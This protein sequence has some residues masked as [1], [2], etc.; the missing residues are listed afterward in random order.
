MTKFRKVN[1]NICP[2][3]NLKNIKKW[4]SDFFQFF[5]GL[6]FFTNI[7]EQKMNA[8]VV[9]DTHYFMDIVSDNDGEHY[10]KDNINAVIDPERPL[11]IQWNGTT[12]CV[13]KDFLRRV[14]KDSSNFDS[15]PIPL[16]EKVMLF[17][18][19]VYYI[20][21]AFIKEL[22]ETNLYDLVKG[23]EGCFAVS[24]FEIVY[25]PDKL[26]TQKLNGVVDEFLLPPS[27]LG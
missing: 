13:H 10:V 17:I 23:K 19:R 22:K 1:K 20:D 18:R 14:E 2:L 8:L 4:S 24:A 9:D 25:Y 6:F 7:S 11:I 26:V 16:S 21:S 3:Q 15:I 27:L 12:Y 5:G